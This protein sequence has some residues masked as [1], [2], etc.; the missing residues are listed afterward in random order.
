M[1]STGDTSINRKP[2]DISVEKYTENGITFVRDKGYLKVIPRIGVVGGI[3]VVVGSV[4]GSG[5]FIS[6]KGAL[7]YSG[8]VGLALIIWAVCGL[9]SMLLASIYAALGSMI[10]KSGGDFT[11]IRKGIGE[12]PAFLSSYVQTFVTSPGSRTV[13]ALVFADYMCA[14]IFG[15][16]GPPDRIRKVIAATEIMALC[17]TNLL[18]VRFAMSMQVVF[19]T[20]KFLALVI[21]SV[22]GVVYLAQGY[23]ASFQTGFEGSIPEATSIS[24]ALYSC[25]WA[26][27]GYNNINEM[28]EELIQP[29]KN[30]PKVLVISLSLITLIYLTTNV[31][32]FTLLSKS[33]FLS[34]SAVAFQ[35]GDKVLG[36]ASIII[37]LSVMCSVYGASNGGFFTDGRVRFAAARVGHLPEV[38]SFLHCKTHIPSLAIITNTMMSLIFLVPGDIGSLINMLGFVS[39][40]SL[41][42]VIISYVRLRST[43]KLDE[44]VFKI[45]LV[46]PILGALFCIFML[47]APFLNSP[48]I[49]FM[50]GVAFIAGGLLLYFPFV[51]FKLKLPG[52]DW[53]TMNIQMLLQICPTVVESEM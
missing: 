19:S 27:G 23:F 6:P 25:M 28:A 5:I 21:I 50:Y 1:E 4:I 49:E 31:S 44:D 34:S 16:C 20:A 2:S 8:S 53:V 9:I 29:R 48:K 37:P 17:V 3:A 47:V 18:S 10:P 12:C 32:Y 26:Y 40:V 41:F 33:E 30:I 46:I 24:L 14:P 52:T 22:G 38:L 43:M 7:K 36:S 15:A 35:W 11:Y 13:L 45:P 39:Y 42:F 51:F